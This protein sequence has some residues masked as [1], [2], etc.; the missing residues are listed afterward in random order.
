MKPSHAIA[1]LVAAA[2]CLWSAPTVPS[3]AKTGVSIKGRNITI[4]VPID[5]IGADRRTVREWKRAAES[6]WNDAFNANDNPFKGCF[7][8]KL[9][10]DIEGHDYSYPA[11]PGRHLIFVSHGASRNQA[12]GPIAYNGNPYHSSADGNFDEVFGDGSHAKH[13]AHEVGHLLGLPDEYKVVGTSPRRTEPLDGRKNTLM[14]DGGRIDPALMKRLVDR[15]RN[16]THNIPDGEW[17]EAFLYDVT[18]IGEKSGSEIVQRME[19]E[20]AFSY[21]YTARYPRVPV[22]VEHECGTGDIKIDGPSER[23]PHPGSGSLDRYTWRDSLTGKAQSRQL[24]V[25]YSV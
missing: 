24:A 5:A 23:E 8:L 19:G 10:V 1:V 15:L 25:M 22:T 16:E 2:V 4:T 12:P 11:Q 3:V 21:A 20:F 7:N 13:L 9:V 14:A 6:I 18:V 17:R